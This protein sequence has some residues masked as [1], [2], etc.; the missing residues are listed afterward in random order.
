MRNLISRSLFLLA[1]LLVGILGVT[2]VLVLLQ[3]DSAT[4]RNQT[5]SDIQREEKQPQHD[6]VLRSDSID[7]G[8]NDSIPSDIDDLV[9]PKHAFDRKVSI[10]SWVAALSDDQILNWLD[11]SVDPSWNEAETNRNELQTALLQKLSITAPKQAFEFAWSL[12]DQQRYGMGSK[13]IMAWAGT[14]LD[15]AIAHVKRM[16]VVDFP[17]FLQTILQARDDLHLDRQ[18]EIA[19]ELGD[20]SYAFSNYFQNLTRGQVENPKE[21]WFEIVNL[22]NREGV[23]ETTGYA[24]SRVALALIEREGMTVL[25]EVLP[26]IS[27]DSEYSPALSQIFG[28]LSTD[29]PADVFDYVLKNLGD[30]AHEVIRSSGIIYNWAQKNPKEMLSKAEPLPASILRQNLVSQAVWQWA[31]NNPRQLLEQLELVPQAQREDASRNAV[32]TLVKTSP[33]E[34]VEYVLQI[35]D[36]STQLTIANTLVREWANQDVDAAKEWV[37]NLPDNEPLRSALF[38]PFVHSLVYSDPRAAFQLALEQPIEEQES[39]QFPAI[40]YEA[41]ILSSIANYDL[42]L[43]I[44]LLLQVR[45]EGDSKMVAYRSVGVELIESGKSQQ[46]MN[47]ATQLSGEQQTE[48]YFSVASMWAIQ[49]PKGLLKAFDEFPTDEVKSK[50]ALSVNYLNNTMQSYS[51][52]E[53]AS[54]D[55]YLNKEDREILD[56]IKD[57]D[58]MNPSEEDLKKLQEVFPY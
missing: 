31:A 15:G 14:D 54:I 17:H 41:S 16:D 33:S 46:A 12:D 7:Q 19:K 39:A 30:H 5:F 29:E 52:E 8:T 53:I 43:A 42:D 35:S 25:D 4:I 13:V 34:A 48:Y 6:K 3:D 58:W 2:G 11:Q 27:Q 40:S 28:S 9:F 55:K 38:R 57:I 32:R 56:K 18:R 36:F 24:L 21:T 47:L 51:A 22:A 37:L 1:G 44:E 50:I 20:E 23:Q 26:S 45:D 49:D 10:V